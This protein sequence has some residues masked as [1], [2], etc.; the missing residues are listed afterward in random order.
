MLRTEENKNLKK[1]DS[2]LDEI[3]ADWKKY[4]KRL[5]SL[6][7]KDQFSNK[8]N[9]K[10]KIRSKNPKITI[11]SVIGLALLIIIF[12]QNKR[13]SKSS[14]SIDNKQP[15]DKPRSLA[16]DNQIRKKI[17]DIEKASPKKPNPKKNQPPIKGQSLKTKVGQINNLKEKLTT[18]TQAKSLKEIPPTQGKSFFVQVGAF[19]IKNNATKLAK[20][21]SLKGF[22][23]E[24]STQRTKTTKHLVHS[25]IFFNEADA[26][27]K[28]TEF[29]SLGLSP[30]IEKNG[31]LYFLKLGI[32][33]KKQKAITFIKKL[34]NNEVKVD[35][36]L[37]EAYREI[38]PVLVKNLLTESKAQQ[39]K[40][41]LIK[42]GFIKSFIKLR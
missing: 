30:S 32:F 36:K 14:Q 11:I 27:S 26:E 18:T 24:V 34:E 3:D 39:T 17:T 22:K 42:L 38:Y 2:Q 20:K 15:S 10:N 28:L 40:E 16:L 12:A 25:G 6:I 1:N 4:N 19:S 23:A 13:H 9:T 21:L 31:E 7:D 37:V 41:A 8:I 29:K 5:D 35:T 33:T